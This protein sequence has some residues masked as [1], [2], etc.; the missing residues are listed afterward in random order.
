MEGGW[1]LNLTKIK[2]PLLIGMA[3]SHI[4]EV[5]FP[6]R[7]FV[8]FADGLEFTRTHPRVARDFGSKRVFG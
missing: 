6:A 2:G 8:Q 4:R 7:R 3:S 5:A 1:T